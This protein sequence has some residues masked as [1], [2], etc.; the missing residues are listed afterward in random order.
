MACRGR[1]LSGQRRWN[2]VISGEALSAGAGR[3]ARMIVG[4]TVGA[5]GDFDSARVSTVLDEIMDGDRILRSYTRVESS[6]VMI[7]GSSTDVW[8]PGNDNPALR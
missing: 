1:D 5:A 3:W 8:I 6:T 7:E 2:A 4:K